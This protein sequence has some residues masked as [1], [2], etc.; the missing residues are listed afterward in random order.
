MPRCVI[1][2]SIISAYTVYKC[3]ENYAVSPRY[4]TLSEYATKHNNIRFD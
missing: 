1:D 4:Y 3:Q 2:A